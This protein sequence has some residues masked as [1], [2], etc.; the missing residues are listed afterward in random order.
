MK[1][2]EQW[3]LNN[4]NLFLPLLLILLGWGFY[5]SQTFLENNEVKVSHNL[6]QTR[7][8]SSIQTLK[9]N[10]LKAS[11]KPTSTLKNKQV[12]IKKPTLFK[13]FKPLPEELE[14]FKNRHSDEPSG[15]TMELSGL[16]VDFEAFKKVEHPLDLPDK[17]Q[18]PL[19]NGKTVQVEQK[20]VDYK[21]KDSFVWVGQVDEKLNQWVHLS[22][23][24]STL[25]GALHASGSDYRIDYLSKNKHLIRKVNESLL[26]EPIDDVVEPEV[27][28][29]PSKA[30]EDALALETT[31]SP[32]LIANTSNPVVIDI[33]VA[34]TQRVS[35]NRT[36]DEILAKIN[37]LIAY[38]NTAHSTSQT[39]VIFRLTRA[40][41]TSYTENLT[42][43]SNP[44]S[45]LQRKTDGVMDEIHD[46]RDETNSDLV[47]LLQ[48]KYPGSAWYTQSKS[49]GFGQVYDTNSTIFAHETGHNLSARH[50]RQ[51]TFY[52]PSSSRYDYGYRSPERRLRT[53]MAYPCS[54]A[55][56]GEKPTSSCNHR[57]PA[58]SSPRSINGEVPYG[59]A[60]TDNSR[61]IKESAFRVSNIYPSGS[62]DQTPPRIISQPT[63]KS[64][65]ANGTLNLSVTASGSSLLYQWY[66]EGR[67]ISNQTNKTLLISNV[68]QSDEGRYRVKISNSSSS[69]Y[70]NTVTV[71]IDQ[72]PIITLQPH[73]TTI[74]VND[75]LSLSVTANGENPLTYQWY[76]N[77]VEIL[78]QT[79]KTLLIN[80]VS[81]SDEG[82]YKVKVS[83]AYGSVYSN[84]ATVNVRLSP[85]IT[86]QPQNTTIQVN[87]NLSLSVN[88]SGEGSLN[89]QWYK[90]NI[91][92]PSKTN[93]TLLISNVSQSDGGAY[94]VK[95][96]NSYGSVY[97]NTV[98]VNIKLSP[99]IT[100]QPQNT[101]IKANNPS[102]NFLNLLKQPFFKYLKSNRGFSWTQTVRR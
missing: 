99:V 77:S 15:F 7:S 66:K 11:L 51:N 32:A 74:N 22:F 84:A 39:G 13:T 71:T 88:A 90:N 53:I 47:T 31:H 18:I 41:E 12:E 89:Y 34:Y 102:S 43:D 52:P 98:T 33:L 87:N 46:I 57:V 45:L 86:L 35:K 20:R 8:V 61:K 3:V 56:F 63:S 30:E 10:L 14:E 75:S 23:Y 83:N 54:Y 21:K 40:V 93:K 94:K 5:S 82:T 59:D 26:P 1:L 24:K 72:A 76:K 42:D 38:T 92:M 68:S 29:A 69:I 2:K 70:S 6:N 60:I 4:K 73:S 79:S 49:T 17:L 58:F 101:I 62:T 44:L 19:P 91:E 65:P 97:S 85:V 27:A 48:K 28:N 100:L 81:Q 64:L 25:S 78:N 9:Q 36:H 16:N 67:A 37:N 80:N 95:V 50:D 96:S 55:A